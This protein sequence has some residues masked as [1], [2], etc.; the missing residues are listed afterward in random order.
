MTTA[1]LIR[2]TYFNYIIIKT[3]DVIS[4]ISSLQKQRNG[5]QVLIF[6]SF[7]F[8]D[9]FRHDDGI[10]MDKARQLALVATSLYSYE[11]TAYTK[12]MRKGVSLWSSSGCF[13]AGS[14]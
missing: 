14:A 8:F 4:S 9:S 12:V 5:I 3:H 1:I 10:M 7:I 13:L 11:K 6:D 2:F